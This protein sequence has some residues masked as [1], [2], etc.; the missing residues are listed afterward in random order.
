M[1]PLFGMILQQCWNLFH[2]VLLMD[3]Q[4]PPMYWTRKYFLCHLPRQK[5]HSNCTLVTALITD[6]DL[7]GLKLQDEEDLQ[8]LQH[9]ARFEVQRWSSMTTSIVKKHLS[10]RPHS[11]LHM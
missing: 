1:K 6:L 4:T 11:Y 8:R 3:E 10:L 5:S 7:I 9:I 2:K